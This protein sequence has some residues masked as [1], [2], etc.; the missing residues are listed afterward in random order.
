MLPLS[1]FH[2]TVNMA[3]VNLF[4]VLRKLS[5]NF[6]F[7]LGFA[8]I[9]IDFPCKKLEEIQ[10]DK[11]DHFSRKREHGVKGTKLLALIQACHSRFIIRR[12]PGLKN[13]EPAFPRFRSHGTG[14]YQK[15]V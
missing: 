4:H 2:E 8:E 10:F 7:L 11:L 13:G 3:S 5:F 12:T 6:I 1:E 15:L 14:S 9:M